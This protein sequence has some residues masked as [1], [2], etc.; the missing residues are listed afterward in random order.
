MG[1]DWKQPKGRMLLSTPAPDVA[2]LVTFLCKLSSVYCM[3]LI[4]FRV[5]K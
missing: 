5:L 3:S 4:D 1:E 2:S